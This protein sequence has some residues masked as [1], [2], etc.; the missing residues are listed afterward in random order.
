M[1]IVDFL[2]EQEP[3]EEIRNTLNQIRDYPELCNILDS[4]YRKLKNC[5]HNEAF[6]KYFKSNI[7]EAV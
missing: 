1:N 5:F 6:Q 7:K 3:N 4:Y 2:L